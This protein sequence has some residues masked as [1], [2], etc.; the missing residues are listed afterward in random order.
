MRKEQ[1]ILE[2]SK[3]IL[4]ISNTVFLAKVLIWALLLAISVS[5][6]L[7]PAWW[8]QAIGAMLG[9][10][11]ITHGVELQHQAL[12]RTGFT[13]SAANRIIGFLLG[14]PL[15][16]SYAHYRD[17]HLHHHQHVGTALD[18]EF[19][20]YSKENNDRAI[21]FL[22]NLFM[23]PHWLKVGK[24][25]MLSLL[26]RPLGKTHN[27]TNETAIRT[28]YILFLFIVITLPLIAVHLNR[29]EWL[30]LVFLAVLAAPIHT[31]IELPEHLGCATHSSTFLNT[32][33]IRS[34]WFM[35]WFTNGNN[36]HVEHHLIPSVIPERLHI[37]HERICSQLVFCNKSYRELA[38]SL[39]AETARR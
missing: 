7:D 10:L 22:L 37:L 13:S 20:Q 5:L 27:S 17:L 25:M 19:F 28:E 16:I 2:K 18:S 26:N 3:D 34:N 1:T 12:H 4:G 39:I 8:K 30:S 35:T 29:F 33:T 38:W 31:L 23:L 14:L 24:L 15:L 21:S 6:F 32:R 11:M 9:A 36:F